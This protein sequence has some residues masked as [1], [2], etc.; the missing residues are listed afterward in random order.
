MSKN[1]LNIRTKTEPVPFGSKCNG[2]QYAWF[3]GQIPVHKRRIHTLYNRIRSNQFFLWRLR[4]FLGQCDSWGLCLHRVWV[5]S[6]VI[7]RKGKCRR[8]AIYIGPKQRK[9]GF[10]PYTNL[11]IMYQALKRVYQSHPLLESVARP[12]LRQP[13]QLSRFLS[14]R[15]RNFFSFYGPRFFCIFNKCTVNVNVL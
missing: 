15:L 5:H 4:L 9:R 7:E 6:Y 2:I 8:S 3:L 12:P 1:N 13:K 11:L 10:H 14:F